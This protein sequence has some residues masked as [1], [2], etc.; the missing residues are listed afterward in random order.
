MVVKCLNDMFFLNP[1]NKKMTPEMD[2]KMFFLDIY[3]VQDFYSMNNSVGYW[4]C[5]LLVARMTVELIFSPG[6]KNVIYEKW[7]SLTN[8]IAK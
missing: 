7:K 5:K 4:K 1:R 6:A 3:I 8:K 2:R